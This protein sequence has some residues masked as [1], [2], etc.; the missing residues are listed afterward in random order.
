MAVTIRTPAQRVTLRGAAQ[1]LTVETQASGRVTVPAVTAGRVVVQGQVV[2]RDRPLPPTGGAEA[3][4]EAPAGV[5]VEIGQPVYIDGNGLIAH[6]AADGWPQ[7]DCAGLA[8]TRGGSGE[9][10]RYASDGSVG[11]A[12]W[13]PITGTVELT[14]G[15]RYFLGPDP[16]TL[17]T[18]IP[19]GASS[20]YALPVGRAVSA[21]TLDIEMGQIIQ[22]LED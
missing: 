7:A 2:Q 8:L 17:T 4:I 1:R 14:V 3:W 11:R 15:A 20:A 10:V 22:L 5:A 13:R 9:P 18:N 6:A 21:T 16:G 12:D 19:T